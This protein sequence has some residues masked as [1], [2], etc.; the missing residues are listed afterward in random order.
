MVT[1]PIFTVEG[2]DVVLYNT[3]EE[4]ESSLETWWVRQH[5]GEIYDAQ[6]HR[7]SATVIPARPRA[8]SWFRARREKVKIITDP[9]F[10]DGGAELA[11]A[12]RGYL[13]NVEKERDKEN[14]QRVSL[15]E[16]VQ[17]FSRITRAK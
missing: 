1:T 10:G 5:E 3:V 11:A 17:Q 2:Y 16:L 7:L 6:G 14:L 15:A 4:A 13:Q 12:L 9:P 8:M